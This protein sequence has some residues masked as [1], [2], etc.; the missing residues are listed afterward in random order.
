MS[1]AVD[2][3]SSVTVA[4]SKAV[5]TLNDKIE[6]LSEKRGIKRMWTKS[7]FPDLETEISNGAIK[8]T[9]DFPFDVVPANVIAIIY[10]ENVKAFVSYV[11]V[12][13][14]SVQFNL[15]QDDGAS[16]FATA[17][18]TKATFIELE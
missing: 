15:R 4:T 8:L 11:S 17:T 13:E 7:G 3:S 6:D 10:P 12:K 2:S 5:K 9:L 18:M 16:F 1:S 14:S